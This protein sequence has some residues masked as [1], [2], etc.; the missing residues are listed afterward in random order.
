M[1]EAQVP[2]KRSAGPV[3]ADFPQEERGDSIRSERWNRIQ[4][5]LNFAILP[6]DS[7]R[8]IEGDGT[9]A[10]N[11]HTIPY[12]GGGNKAQFPPWAMPADRSLVPL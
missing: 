8:G 2:C 9:K 4:Y 6:A 5:P 3:R 7:E 12:H 11:L 10:S 1:C